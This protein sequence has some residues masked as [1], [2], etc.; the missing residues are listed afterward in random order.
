MGITSSLVNVLSIVAVAYPHH[1]N[2]GP[3]RDA[4]RQLVGLLLKGY[5][6][7]RLKFYGT[8]AMRDHDV[9]LQHTLLVLAL[10][11]RPLLL[12]CIA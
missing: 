2:V 11:Q 5:L 4:Q 12:P 9:L 7:A 10:L 1:A 8:G 3:S 6:G